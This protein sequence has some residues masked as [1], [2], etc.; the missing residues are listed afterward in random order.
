MKKYLVAGIAVAAVFAAGSIGY[1]TVSNDCGYDEKGQ[2]HKGGK[3]YA[4]GTMADAKKCA[5]KGILPEVIA[6]RLGAWGNA[7]TKAEAQAI[8]DLN[9]KVIA[10]KKAAEEAARAKA[11]AEAAAK[12]AAEEE[13]ARQAAEAEAAKKAAALLLLQEAAKAK[14]AAPAEVK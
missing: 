3:V 1:A 8:K 10:D 14:A 9:A 11:E 7:K 13:A 6:K 2:F 4:Y 5:E 12:K